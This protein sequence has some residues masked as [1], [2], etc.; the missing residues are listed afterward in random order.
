MLPVGVGLG[1]VGSTSGTPH[2]PQPAKKR[3]SGA[4]EKHHVCEHRAALS[5]QASNCEEPISI[6]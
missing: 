2:I 4:V 3:R 1:V 6:F 5:R